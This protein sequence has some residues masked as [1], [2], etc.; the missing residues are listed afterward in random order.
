[1]VICLDPGHS[2]DLGA[3]SPFGL[4]EK[5]INFVYCQALKEKLEKKGARVFLTRG[6]VDGISLQSRVQF[7]KFVNADIFISMHF[8]GIP[9]GVNPFPLRGVATYYNQPH[10]Y[11]LAYLIQNRMLDYTRAPNFGLYYANLFV[12]RM[13]QT[14][15][16]LVEPGFITHPVEETMIRSK[17]YRSRVVNA[18][19]KALEQFMK[20]SH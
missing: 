1:M 10:S 4:A 16:V 15:S 14:I 13:P 12:C 8:N 18:I 7:A 6:L 19:E 5:E 17:N 9:D 20:E 11:R 3:V 2:P